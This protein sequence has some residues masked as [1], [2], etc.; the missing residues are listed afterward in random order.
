[1]QPLVSIIITT[2]NEEKNIG[3]CL[4]SIRKQA[5][6]QNKLEIIV[7]DNLSTDKTREIAKKYTQNI[8]LKGPERSAQRNYGLN[9][10][11]GEYL[12]YLDADMTLS[13]K[14]ISKCVEKVTRNPGTSGLYITEIV[15]GESYWSRVRRFERS[16]YDATAIDCVR[17][18][19]ATDFKTVNG[20]DTAMTGPEDWDFDKKIRLLGKVGLIKEPIYHNESEFNM[21][22]YLNKKSYY[23]KSFSSYID[24]WGKDDPDVRKQF[25]PIYRYLVVFTERGKW[26]RTL[27]APHLFIGVLLLRFLVGLSYFNSV[28][29]K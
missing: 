24:K 3:S 16:F 21:K 22:K 11:K 14:V 8:F 7:V 25:S 1:M 29:S 18:V 27:T 5:Y 13:P 28:I 20:F 12:L 17:F 15:T 19:R 2:K 4:E 26:K 10:A 23:A 9:K 6:S